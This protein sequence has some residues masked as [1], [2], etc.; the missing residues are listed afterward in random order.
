V[1]VAAYLS[2]ILGVILVYSN[3]KQK[4]KAWNDEGLGWA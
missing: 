4:Q 3:K 2:I 1:V